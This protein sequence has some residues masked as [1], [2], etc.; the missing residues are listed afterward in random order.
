MKKIIL[1]VFLFLISSNVFCQTEYDSLAPYKTALKLNLNGFKIGVEQKFYKN[2]TGQF[3]IG[4]LGGKSITF[5][6]Q[7]RIYKKIFKGNFAYVG[8]AYFYK[9]QL[10]KYNDTVQKFESD[11][12]YSDK[13]TKDF[14][15]NRY[16]HAITI[17]SGYYFVEKIFKQKIILELN[18]G[19]GVRY[20]KSSRYGLLPNEVLDL[21]EAFI[22]RPA[23]YL[24]T[25]G[26]FRAYPELNLNL[27]LIIPLKK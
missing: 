22:I 20:K 21:T 23:K 13:Y 3:E 18:I 25:N 4:T 6:P 7:V 9:H 19:V 8:L 2:I 26:E 27:S 15:V 10:S 5:K 11:G 16:I 17:N 24:E 1:I 12:T 14:K